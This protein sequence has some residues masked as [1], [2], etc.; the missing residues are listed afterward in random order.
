MKKTS[1]LAGLKIVG[2]LQEVHTAWAGA[3]LLIG[4]FRKLEMDKIA[5]KETG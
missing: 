4:L 1:A 2:G 3:T 5:N